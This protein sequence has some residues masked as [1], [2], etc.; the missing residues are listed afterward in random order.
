M[1]NFIDDL[2]RGY[3][4]ISKFS[5]SDKRSGDPQVAPI[6]PYE[7]LDKCYDATEEDG[8]SSNTPHRVGIEDKSRHKEDREIE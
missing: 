4:V 3:Q 6:W 5:R 7:G 1:W 8:A 2:E